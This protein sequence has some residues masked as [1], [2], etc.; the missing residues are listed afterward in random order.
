MFTEE[1]NWSP[2]K[3]VKIRYD[4]GRPLGDPLGYRQEEINKKERVTY[5]ADPFLWEQ[6]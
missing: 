2:S 5:F 6:L 3:L 1:K 4:R